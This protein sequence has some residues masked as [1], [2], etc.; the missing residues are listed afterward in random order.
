[1]SRRRRPPTDP[2]MPNSGIRLLALRSRCVTEIGMDHSRCEAVP[3]WWT[4]ED[5]RNQSR[6]RLDMILLLVFEGFDLTSVF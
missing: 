6:C 1:M 3:L 2:D 4:V 5:W